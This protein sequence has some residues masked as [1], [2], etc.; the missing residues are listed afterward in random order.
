MHKQ[1]SHHVKHI[2]IPDCQVKAGVPLAHLRWAGLYIAEKR[3][4]VVV[5]IGDFADMP[6]LS[7]YDVGKRSFEGRRY[8]RD[9]E[10]AKQAM[11]LLMEPIQAARGYK[12]RLELFLGNHEDRITRAGSFVRA[13]GK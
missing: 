8:K 7:S 5:Q 3:P 9:I 13:K 12:P 1:S 2:V 10:A 11:G 6:S 4:D